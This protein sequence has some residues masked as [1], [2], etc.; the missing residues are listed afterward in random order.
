MLKLDDANCST[1]AANHDTLK[2]VVAGTPKAGNTWVRHLLSSVYGLP[3]VQLNADAAVNEWAAFGA[4]WIGQE[5]FHPTPEIVEWAAR[6]GVIFVTP[7]R[8]PADVL[9][10]LRHHVQNQVEN[11]SE[12]VLNPESMLLDEMDV[13]G[14]HSR[15][16]VERGFYLN[17]HLSIYWLRGGWS[18]AVR[19]EDLWRHPV[20]TLRGLT[21]K[22]VPVS[23]KRLR[24][25]IA[26]C[27]V[28]RMQK[29]FDPSRKFVRQGG[30]ASWTEELPDGIQQLL[31][32]HEPYPTQFAALGYTMRKD[33]PAN[34]RLREPSPTGNPFSATV[35][36]NGVPVAPIL[37]D[38][39]LD[40]PET[41]TSGW[42]D[43]AAVDEN[44]FYAW[45]LRPAAADPHGGQLRPVITE[46]AHYLHRI[47]P[48]VQEAFPEPFDGQRVTFGDWFLY[49]AAKEYDFAP[50]FGLPVIRSWAEGGPLLADPVN[51]TADDPTGNAARFS[52]AARP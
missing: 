21:A 34:A 36:S 35:F 31:G 18:H 6:S 30:V 37:V 46:L 42:S 32:T 26:A 45:L 16:F 52:V 44:S 15:A 39:F 29:Q 47:R 14:A 51:E 25:A 2:I 10:S 19:Y 7:V 13:Y 49:S 24:H 5:H 41:L 12:D 3:Q 4:R 33:D 8:H 43:P 28:G 22:I 1:M 27:E 9:V 17:L 40:L 38:A 23:D 11:P 20:E 48:D 50:V